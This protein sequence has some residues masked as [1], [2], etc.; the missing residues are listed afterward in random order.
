MPLKQF[1][2]AILGTNRPKVIAV[3]G[4]TRADVAAAMAHARTG[5]AHLPIWAWCAE[6]AAPVDGCERFV[7]RANAWR[8]RRDLRSA[9]PALSIVPWTGG[10]P[11]TRRAPALKLIAFTI[12]PFR[13]V[14]CNEAGGFVAGRP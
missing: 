10:M 3:I 14:I 6:D 4:L 11:G 9:W 8:V 7:P 1:L 5:E 2:G 13:V 12:P